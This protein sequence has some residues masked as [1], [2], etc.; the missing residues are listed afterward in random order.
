MDFHTFP[1]LFLRTVTGFERGNSPKEEKVYE[2]LKSIRN[3][4]H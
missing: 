2:N 1:P 4:V 3:D